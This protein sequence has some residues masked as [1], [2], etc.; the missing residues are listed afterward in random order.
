[1]QPPQEIRKVVEKVSHLPENALS[2]MIVTPLSFESVPIVAGKDLSS[3]IGR[4]SNSSS[5]QQYSRGYGLPSR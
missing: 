4:K 1:M 5:A 3:I 2:S